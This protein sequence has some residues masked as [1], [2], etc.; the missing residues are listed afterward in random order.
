M[1]SPVGTLHSL[2]LGFS[3]PDGVFV[4]DFV[5]KST[6]RESNKNYCEHFC[7][8]FGGEIRID[9]TAF[10]RILLPFSES[11]RLTRIIQGYW[12]III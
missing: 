3:I 10:V 1:D 12:A 7:S 8:I 5:F 11:L 4:A 6:D 2:N 9:K